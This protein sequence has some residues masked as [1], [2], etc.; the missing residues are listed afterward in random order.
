MS[1]ASACFL[2]FLHRK[3]KN[4]PPCISPFFLLPFIS[5]TIPVRLL[6][7][8]LKQLPSRST[9]ISSLPNS[10][11]NPFFILYLWGNIDHSIWECRST[12]SLKSS[13]LWPPQ[14]LLSFLLLCL[15]SRC[16]LVLLYLFVRVGA[17]QILSLDLL[18]LSL[19]ISNQK[20]NYL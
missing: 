6:H 12:F 11:G 1:L 4:W 20:P 9:M 2:C 15:P 17:P 8:S 7:H 3:T 14:P 18:F 16:R 10:K 13:L 19:Y 5:Q